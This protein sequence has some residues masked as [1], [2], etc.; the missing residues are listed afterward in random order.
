VKIKK[1]LTISIFSFSLIPLIFLGVFTSK[2]L[3][4]NEKRNVESLIATATELQTKTV[5]SFFEELTVTAKAIVEENIV[6]QSTR[7]FENNTF[8]TQSEINEICKDTELLIGNIKKSNTYIENIYVIDNE[9]NIVA[10]AVDKDDSSILDKFLK[11][12]TI[13]DKNGFS[14]FFMSNN[15]INGTPN[16]IYSSKIFDKFNISHGKVIIICNTSYLQAVLRDGKVFQTT[17]NILVDFKGNIFE[18]P[19]KSIT[20]FA[21]NENYTHLTNAINSSLENINFTNSHYKYANESLDK[22]AYLSRI[23][24]NGWTYIMNNNEVELT[25]DIKNTNLI[26]VYFVAILMLIIVILGFIYIKIILKPIDEISFTLYKKQRGDKYARFEVSTKNEFADISSEF[27]KMV[28]DISESEQRYRTVV[29]MSEN[30]IFEFIIDKDIVRFSDNFNKKFSFRSK[31]EKFQDSFFNNCQVHPD[32]KKEYDKMLSEDFA[33]SNYTQGEFRLKTIYGDFVWFLVRASMLYTRENKPLKVIGVL[34]D[35]DREKKNE[36]RLLQRADYDA[37]T[38][39][40]NRE[41]F[42]KRLVNEFELSRM[43]KENDAV[44]FIDIDDFKHFNDEFG[45]AC[46]DEVLRFVSSKICEIVDNRGF[47]GRYGG[48]EFVVCVHTDNSEEMV[49]EVAK[50][51]ISNLKSGFDSEVVDRHMSINCSIGI[52]F[53]SENGNNLETVIDEA[54]EAM[55]KVKKHGKS[56]YAFYS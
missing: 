33:D 23:T 52:S 9:Q 5:N 21:E 1:N 20:N 38:K 37:L 56:N 4:I 55:Y 2:S 54:D 53:L 48:D 49:A 7:L 16:F 45:H 32:D 40:F 41:T 36:M 30:I 28:D 26:G 25:S 8:L 51:L 39:L 50:N 34:I 44:M 35:I 11:T 31:T 17:H 12:N 13:K 14:E 3:V 15:S 27:N 29:E 46:G 6:I 19:Y 43:R 42:E 24:S 47:G 18:Y 22:I 10:K